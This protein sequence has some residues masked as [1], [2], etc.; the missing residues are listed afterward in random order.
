MTEY[1]S[2]EK[3][4]LEKIEALRAEGI[5]PYP[6]RAGRTHTSLEAVAAFER[7]EKAAREGRLPDEVQVTLAGRLRAMRAMGKVSF[8]HIEDGAGKIQLFL[9]VNELSQERVDF[10]R[11]MVDLGDFI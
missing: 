3:V 5:E 4:R 10:F 11:R 7:A 8:A 1:S 9:R 6:T 2:L